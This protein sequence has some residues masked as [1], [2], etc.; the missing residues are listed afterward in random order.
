MVQASVQHS[1]IKIINIPKSKTGFV[2]LLPHNDIVSREIARVADYTFLTLLQNCK[3]ASWS[4]NVSNQ[5]TM[6]GKVKN[7]CAKFTI[8]ESE[9]DV[10]PNSVKDTFHLLDGKCLC[11]TLQWV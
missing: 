6:C 5:Q 11:V 1:T 10:S 8:G 2:S 3:A 7:Y 4:Q 9:F